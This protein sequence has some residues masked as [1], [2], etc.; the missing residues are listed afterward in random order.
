MLLKN[1]ISIFIYFTDI[2]NNKAKPIVSFNKLQNNNNLVSLTDL[3]KKCTLFTNE[4]FNSY[5]FS[6]TDNSFTVLNDHYSALAS[7]TTYVNQHL[8]ITLFNIEITFNDL[9]PP[10]IILSSSSLHNPLFQ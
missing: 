4:A 7:F 1:E 6:D 10:I 2:S 9:F 8:I 5:Y 3:I